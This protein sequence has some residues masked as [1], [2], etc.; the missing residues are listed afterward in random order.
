MALHPQT[1]EPWLG[2]RTGGVSG[3]TVRAI[4]LAQVDAVAAGVSVPI[5]AMGGVQSGADAAALISAGARLVAV[6]TESFRDAGAGRRI[7]QEL[8]ESPAKRTIPRRSA[9]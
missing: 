6:G 7:A 3:A 5:V 1:G 4:A 9:A 8:G 2:G